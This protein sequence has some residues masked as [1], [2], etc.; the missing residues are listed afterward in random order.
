MDNHNH[1][2]C[3][4]CNAI[5]R[6]PDARLGDSPFC[7][8]CKHPLFTGTPLNLTD[9]SFSA[10]VERSSIPVVVDFWASWCG[11]C[12]MMAPHYARAAGNLEPNV[13]FAKLDTDANPVAAG[14]Y[15]IRSIPTVILFKDGREVARQSGAMDS[16]TLANWIR[17]QI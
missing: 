12:K 7:G 10:H 1:V 8:Q 6:I 3:P 14:R 5:N 4:H 16:N 15:N 11:P 13:R 2:A 9:A 17:G